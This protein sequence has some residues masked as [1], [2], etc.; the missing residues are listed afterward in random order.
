MYAARRQL[1]IY[2]KRLVFDIQF[3]SFVSVCLSVC[4]SVCQSVRTN[5]IIMIF[6]DVNA[7]P[8]EMNIH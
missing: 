8:L 2:A 6:V 4:L 3:A 7:C 1:I 5:E